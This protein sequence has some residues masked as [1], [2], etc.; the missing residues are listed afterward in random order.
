MTRI[1]LTL[2]AVLS[3]WAAL[4]SIVIWRVQ[5]A[6]AQREAVVA[7]QAE[8]LRASES[9]RKRADAALVALRQKNAATARE[10][11]SVTR[12]L[13]EATRAEPA[14]ADQPIPKGVLDALG[15]P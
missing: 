13:A 12:S 15:Q 8:A 1:L 7:S 3:V 10:T 11:A 9:A 5:R 6:A 4:S 14:W 2:I